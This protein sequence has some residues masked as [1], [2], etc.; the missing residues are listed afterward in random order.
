[1]RPPV[2]NSG[3]CKV[4]HYSTSHESRRQNRRRPLPLRTTTPA[5]ENRLNKYA[6]F[7]RSC[8]GLVIYL[9]VGIFDDIA[10][11]FIFFG[12]ERLKF[13]GAR[14]CL[15]LDGR[16]SQL[17]LHLGLLSCRKRRLVQLLDYRCRCAGRSDQADPVDRD[18]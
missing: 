4:R 15:Y 2:L 12:D 13:R 8:K 18:K 9:D 17:L 1:T 5:M 16:L 6:Y 11:T 14:V 3:R 7:S 10:P